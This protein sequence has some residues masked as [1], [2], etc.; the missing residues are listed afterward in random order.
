MIFSNT[1]V[2]EF[3][4]YKFTVYII[5]GRSKCCICS[6]DESNYLNK[7][8]ECQIFKLLNRLIL[9][10]LRKLFANFLWISKHYHYAFFAL[11]LVEKLEIYIKNA[12]ESV[13]KSV[14]H[15]VGCKTNYYLDLR[16]SLH[17][18]RER[19]RTVLK[20]IFFFIF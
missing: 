6:R 11:I 3:Q 20:H 9:C 5:K 16:C 8:R 15:T 14:L 17:I 1:Y 13:I 12:L 19:K 18:Q 10:I 4:T 7:I 2:S